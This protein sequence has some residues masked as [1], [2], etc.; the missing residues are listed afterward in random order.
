MA[1]DLDDV[2]AELEAYHL[3]EL[4]RVRAARAAGASKGASGPAAT[5]APTVHGVRRASGVGILDVIAEIFEASPNEQFTAVVINDLLKERG[6]GQGAQDPV[7]S[8]RG[9]LSRLAARGLIETVHRGV[10]RLKPT[11]GED[12][13]DSPSPEPQT[14]EGWNSTPES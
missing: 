4:Q 12:V 10:Y 8:V 11:P 9:A 14:D 13:S 2:L 5:V 3:G 1:K 7:N 6:I